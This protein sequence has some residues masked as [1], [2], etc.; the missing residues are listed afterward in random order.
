MSASSKLCRTCKI[1]YTAELSLMNRLMAFISTNVGYRWSHGRHKDLYTDVRAAYIYLQ[2]VCPGTPFDTQQTQS[3]ASQAGR[4]PEPSSRT[5]SRAVVPERGLLRRP[6]SGP[7][8]VRDA[9]S[10]S[11]RGDREVGSSRTL[12]R[13]APNV[14]PGRSRLR[15]SGIERPDPQASRA[16]GR[17]QAHARSDAIYRREDCRGRSSRRPSARSTDQDRTGCAGPPPQYRT[18]PGA[19]KKR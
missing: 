5:C 7:G 4:W 17:T 12:R 3:S 10:G 8:E 2:I 11:H 18:R 13:V 14:L 1:I 15:A 19:E 6:R 9:A 16:E